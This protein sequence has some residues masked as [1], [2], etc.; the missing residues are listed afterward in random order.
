MSFHSKII[1]FLVIKEQAHSQ[2]FNSRYLD[3]TN[4]QRKRQKLY[5]TNTGSVK[6]GKNFIDRNLLGIKS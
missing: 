3:I 2:V 6:L 4:L 5:D 1:I